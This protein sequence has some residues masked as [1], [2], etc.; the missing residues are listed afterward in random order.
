MKLGYDTGNGK[1]WTYV[2][3]ESANDPSPGKFTLKLDSR[4]EN[5]VLF[6]NG[7]ETYWN[8]TEADANVFG[9]P[10]EMSLNMYNINFVSDFDMN[11]L[12]YYNLTRKDDIVRFTINS[13]GQL[14][15]FLLLENEWNLFN[16]QPGQRCDFYAYCGANSSCT[17]L[18]TPESECS[19]LPGFEP[20]FP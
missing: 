11:Y 6:L 17:N 20:S 7:N 13:T 4:Q 19:F 15:Q 5:H 9:F 1:N 10:P 3:W 12:T 16:S 14:Q 8:S 2:S 18:S